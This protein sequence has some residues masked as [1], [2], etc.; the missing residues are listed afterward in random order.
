MPLRHLLA[1][2][3][4]V[5]LSLALAACGGSDSS[6]ATPGSSTTTPASDSTSPAPTAPPGAGQSDS[7]GGTSGPK[8]K[9]AMKALRTFAT[10]MRKRGVDVSDPDPSDPIAILHSL[11]QN[12]PA[13]A[14]A[15]TACQGTLAALN[16]GG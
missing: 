14:R 12:D 7:A 5:S 8:N 4:I 6:T 9:K 15:L 2:L 1:T 3:L 11:D 13:V 10:C 16:G